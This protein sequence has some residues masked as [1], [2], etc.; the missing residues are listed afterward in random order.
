MKLDQYHLG[1]LAADNILGQ[2][3]KTLVNEK[4]TAGYYSVKW[5][6]TNETGKKVSSGIYIYKMKSGNFIETKKLI[7]LQ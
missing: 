1:R 6:G 2:E 3:V 7:I 5:D 4:K